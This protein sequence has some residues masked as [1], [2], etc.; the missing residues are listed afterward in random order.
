MIEKHLKALSQSKYMGYVLLR[1][2]YD[3]TGLPYDFIFE[4][5]NEAYAALAG[6][7]QSDF[8]NNSI[9]KVFPEIDSIIFDW[10][11]LF[12]ELATHGGQKAFNYNSE[13]FGKKLH[14]QLFSDNRYYVSMIIIDTGDGLKHLSDK[15]DDQTIY[16]LFTEYSSVVIWILNY[17]IGRF[18][19]VSPSVYNLRGFSVDE[20]LAEAFEN[21]IDKV[22]LE[23]VLNDI[24]KLIY[25]VYVLKNKPPT[26]Y[27]EVQQ[28]CKDGT[29]V[30]VEMSCN[31][32]LNE[33]SEIE[34]FGICKNIQRRK[35]IELALKASEEQYRKLIENSQDIIFKLHIDGDF[36]FISPSSS[37]HLG[38][39]S[40]EMV[41]NSI[42]TY[43]H[44]DDKL[45]FQNSLE[46]LS[47]INAT[48]KNLEI[49][50]IDKNQNIQWFSVSINVVKNQNNTVVAFD[51]IARNI[52]EKHQ[53]DEQLR[54]LS[55]VVEQSPN[56]IMIITLHGIVEYVNQSYINIS[57]FSKDELIGSYYQ[58]MSTDEDLD[59][60]QFALLRQAI[61][62]CKPWSGEMLVKKKSGE[63]YWQG[64][65]ISPILNADRKITHY[66]A[67]SQDITDRKK[68]EDEFYNLNLLLEKSVEERTSEL[69]MTNE[70][71]MQEIINRKRR[72][73]EIQ[74]AREDAEKAY[75]TKTEF[76]SRMSHEL[77]T[78]LNSILGFAQLLEMGELNPGQ[79]KGVR[80]ILTSG[81]HL[82]KL[83]NE[84]LDISKIEAGKFT[85]TSDIVKLKTVIDEAIDLVMPLTTD[86]QIVLRNLTYEI[87]GLAIETDKQ[88][89]VQ[90]LVNLLNNAIKYNKP[91]GKVE[92][93]VLLPED[94]QTDNQFLKIIIADSGVGMTPESLSKLFIPFE[95]I[96]Q[97][98]SVIEGTGLGLSIAKEI[99]I[100][101]GGDIKA[102]SV[103]GEGSRF[104]ILLPW[105]KSM[106][107]QA[108]I[109][110]ADELDDIIKII[111]KGTIL[112]IE[113]DYSNIEL[114][115][116][117][118]VGYRPEIRIISDTHG[119]K[120]LNLAIEH[121]PDLIFLD[122]DLPDI[123]VKQVLEEIKNNKNTKILP[124]IILSDN[125]SSEQIRALLKAGADD[126]LFKPLNV[127]DVLNVIDKYR[128]TN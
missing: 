72:E 90:V 56:M 69:S 15:T 60:Y 85:L 29:M 14:V 99:I 119:S 58:L 109:Y 114:L 45:F 4:E 43:I 76:I 66:I 93:S 25:E 33:I 46:Y 23:P 53:S 38:Y 111:Q 89:L 105:T 48:S 74:T 5:T 64:L 97:N 10:L 113:N 30:W 1:V 94:Q 42:L 26:Y 118:I 79:R 3:D 96:D 70:F 125:L 40:H 73:S 12:G 57:G 87:N 65:S 54:K 52:T 16:K 68:I 117:I 24:N 80:H 62:D 123:P 22:S 102:E 37:N 47:E 82:L 126:V 88:R 100:A 81:K 115:E 34:I 95:R 84:V 112:H 31:I 116:D 8:I 13:L 98:D 20:A 39:L 77:R 106:G 121:M 7:K 49:R 124:V 19:Y 11:G 83:I 107:N 71:L 110:K 18:I 86:K 103:L 101:M 17:S 21:T 50:F 35:T 75:K 108:I 61:D 51:G 67:I 28:P 2:V 127:A 91:Q 27:V 122:F 78:P 92:L 44:E 36:I 104:S 128:K 120:A 63:L 59:E 32:R 41:G 55:Q 9:K 6:K